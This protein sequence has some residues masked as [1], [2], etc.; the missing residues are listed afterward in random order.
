MPVIL[1]TQKAEIERI[2]VQ[3][4]LRAKW[5]G[6]VAQVEDTLNS[7]SRPTKKKTKNPQN[8]SWCVGAHL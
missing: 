8:Q 7:N 3:G 4:Q 1:V 6:E 5:T 2:R